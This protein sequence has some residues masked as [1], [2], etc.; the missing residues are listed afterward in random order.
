VIPTS[1][2]TLYANTAS[3]TAINGWT[4]TSGSVDWIGT[5]WP[6][7]PVGLTPPAHSVDL[8]GNSVGAISQTI[9]TVTGHVYTLNFALNGNPDGSPATKNVNVTAGSTTQLFTL[10]SPGNPPGVTTA[11]YVMESL[12]FTASGSTTEITFASGDPAIPGFFGPVI[13]DVSVTPEPR[14]YAVL[15]L[16]LSGLFFTMYRRRRT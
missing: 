14:F 8:D 6:A 2:Q 9:N 7:V 12:H 16:G 15:G 4:V 1:Y 5:Y 10:I 13:A 11:N 3:A